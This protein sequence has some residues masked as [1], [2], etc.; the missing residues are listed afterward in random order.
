MTR[1]ALLL[2]VSC[3]LLVGSLWRPAWTPTSQQQAAAPALLLDDATRHWLRHEMVF[4]G[5]P[6]LA[7]AQVIDGEVVG[8]EAFGVADAWRRDPLRPGHLHEVAS[9]SKLVTA[10]AAARAVTAGD[11]D[12]HQPLRA[13]R[14]HLPLVGEY[15][16]V[17]TLGQ[18]LSHSAGLTN[19]LGAAPRADGVPG[20][21]FAYSGQGFEVVGEMLALDAGTT[22]A[23]LFT[24]Q[25]LRPLGMHDATYARAHDADRLARPH[26][27]VNLPWTLFALVT[28]AVF[29]PLAL[30]LGAWARWRRPL[31]KRAPAAALVIAVTAGLVAPFALL[32]A[33]NAW[34]N[35]AADLVLVALF[36]LGTAG[37]RRWRGARGALV[38]GVVALTVAATLLLHLPM[39]LA[40]RA[41]R[42]PAA[43]GLRTNAHDLGRL[44]A[45]FAAPPRDWQREVALIT[46]P[47]IRLDESNAWGLGI[48]IQ[49]IGG[50]T[51]LWHWGVNFPGYQSWLLARPATRDGLVVL[52]DGGSMSVIGGRNRYSGLELARELAVRILPG[53]HGGYWSAVP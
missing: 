47:Q 33:E 49:T 22:P 8:V 39:P 9:N 43:A 10:L 29:L 32:G 23:E 27:D 46:S 4:R 14:P 45:V 18:L 2:I 52:M 25:V 44:A 26:V 5:V 24:H 13:Q 34:R 38:A 16:D 1:I 51:T 31:P 50:S 42:F 30:T 28:T 12:L 37:W 11:L 15:A 19:G 7:I 3:I 40:E 41:A 21:R 36:G 6:G 53:P 20:T 48:G 17:V 35:V